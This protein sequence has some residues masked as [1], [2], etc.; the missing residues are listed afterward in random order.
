MSTVR[1]LCDE[2]VPDR[3]AESLLRQEPAIDILIVGQE[4]APPKGTRD[5]DLLLAAEDAE[6]LLL[7]F[8][9]RTMPQHVANH[10]AA[11][12]HTWG[13]LILNQGFPL[14]RYVDD[15]FVIWG[16]RPPRIGVTGLRA[17]P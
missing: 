9:R 17:F 2:N 8:D 11:G 7:T 12:H 1:F 16:L 5:P 4:G 14:R 15:L 10:L 13:I 3:L 6:R